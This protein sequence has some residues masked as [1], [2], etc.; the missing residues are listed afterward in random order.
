MWPFG[1]ARKPKQSTPAS[2]SAALLAQVFSLMAAAVSAG[3]AI[4]TAQ[5]PSLAEHGWVPYLLI[6]IS[7]TFVW[8]ERNALTW[9]WVRFKRADPLSAWLGIAFF[10]VAVL[11]TGAMQLTMLSTVFLSQVADDQRAEANLGTAD[12]EI[13]RLSEKQWAQVPAATSSSLRLEI[14]DLEKDAD[15]KGKNFAETARTAAAALIKKRAELSL[16]VAY[17]ND[18][19][20]LQSWREKRAKLLGTPPADTK[21]AAISGL[22]KAMGGAGG[23]SHTSTYVLILVIVVALQLGQTTLPMIAGKSEIAALKAAAFKLEDTSEPIIIEPARASDAPGGTVPAV[24]A[25]QAQEAPAL[26]PPRPAPPPS[27]PVVITVEP[28]TPPST[29]APAPPAEPRKLTAMAR[30]ILEAQEQ[31]QAAKKTGRKALAKKTEPSPPKPSPPRP[32]GGLASR[33]R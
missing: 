23:T 17:E 15:R 30:A 12:A 5:S 7:I 4:I 10:V 8:Y 1:T 18:Q 14:K 11:Y 32:T 29:P 13:K 25:V 16:A 6:A 9:I 19:S 27:P 22:L 21:S 20:A 28:V 3:G 2:K 31:E 24:A 26:P 33:I